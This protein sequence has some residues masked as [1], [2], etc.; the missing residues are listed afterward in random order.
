[1]IT[2]DLPPLANLPDEKQDLLARADPRF[3]GQ[4]GF[5]QYYLSPC[6]A[7]SPATDDLLSAFKPRRLSGGL[8]T[9]Q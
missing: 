7:N 9:S 5:V 6:D 4:N 3:D 2:Y 1:V 8:A